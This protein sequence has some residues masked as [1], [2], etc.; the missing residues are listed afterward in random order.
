M[1]KYNAVFTYHIEIPADSLEEATD[2]A[3]E[4]YEEEAHRE[5]SQDFLSLDIEEKGEIKCH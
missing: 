1:K 3:W 2:K 4:H 5:Y